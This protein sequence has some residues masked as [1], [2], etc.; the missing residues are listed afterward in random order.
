MKLI[1]SCLAAFSM[2]SKIPTPQFEWKEDD[3][4]YM[5]CFFPWIGAVIGAGIWLWHMLCES[6]GIGELC[7]VA[8]GVLIPI[9]VTGGFHIDGFMD[10]MDAFHSYQPREKKLEILKDPH[11]GAFAVIM[12]AAYGLL[13][14]GAFSQIT[15]PMCLAVFCCG[16]FMARCLSGI[17]VV[18]W[19][20]AKTDGLLYLFADTAQKRIVR[21]S[22]YIQLLLCAAGML[23]LSLPAGL[24][25]IVAA[26][27]SFLYYYG[28]SKKELG[29]ITGDTAG[30]FVTVCEGSMAVAAAI[31]SVVIS[32]GRG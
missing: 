19:K 16:F 22:L 17:A 27:G 1:R 25:V 20:S 23:Y 2:Y 6:K 26:M 30:S 15:D 14:L 3:M 21:V 8:V 31:V 18:S 11:I 28:K 29:G 12:L 24:A 5:L 32:S 4:R 10:T 13:F 7:Y 9:V